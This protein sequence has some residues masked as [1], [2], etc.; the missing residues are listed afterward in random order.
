[1]PTV[2]PLDLDSHCVAS[3]FL[4]DV[5]FFA[6]ADGAVHF[7]DQGHQQAMVHDGLLC[8]APDPDGASLISGGEDGKVARVSAGGEIEILA[9]MPGKW[10]Q[11]V[12][13]GPQGAIAYAVG[14]SSHVRLSD[15]TEMEF[16]EERSVEDIAFA[17]KG[18]RLAVAR[19]NGV[20][21]HWIGTRMPP[22]DLEWKGAHNAVSFSPDGKYVVT[23][24]QENALHGWRLDNGKHMRMRGYYAKVKSL[25]WSARSKWLA[26]SGAP[27]AVVWPFAG[28]DGPMG[29]AP[30][31][32]GG[33]GDIMVTS[34]TCHPT[35]DVVAIGYADGTI[36]AARISD[37]KLVPM[38]D[39]GKGAISAMTWDSRGVRLAFGT[40][41]GDCGLID[42][43]A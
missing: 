4:N 22:V 33:R 5:P 43:T 34:V 40:E 12:A 11:Q 9:E 16:Q 31:Q 3:A 20:S 29:K 21:L 23:S 37:Q 24:M 19:Y 14:R 27:S 30:L 8:A 6:L 18:M 32:L 17:P 2:A 25:S 41:A 15:G 10:V 36:L 42:L 13:A 1:M 38:R 28:R 39:A 26:S 7:L 35:D